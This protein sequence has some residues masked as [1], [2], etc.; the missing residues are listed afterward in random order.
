MGN[1][2]FEVLSAEPSSEYLTVNTKITTNSD[3]RVYSAKV[4]CIAQNKDSVDVAF[5]TNIVLRNWDGTYIGPDQ[6]IYYD[7]LIR[8]AP[9]LVDHVLFQINKIDWQ[10]L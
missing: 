9:A 10:P 2:G 6:S 1:P 8:V 3:Q 5:T 4:T 7:F